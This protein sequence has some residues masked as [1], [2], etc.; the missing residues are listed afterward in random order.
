MV[1]EKNED[2]T[3]INKEKLEELSQQL[4]LPVPAYLIKGDSR[5]AEDRS[6]MEQLHNGVDKLQLEFNELR[7]K[8]WRKVC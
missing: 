6:T 5:A 7:K 4:M 2:G 8:Y 3:S 1:S